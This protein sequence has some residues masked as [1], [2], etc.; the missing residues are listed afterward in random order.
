MA[1]SNDLVFIHG[2]GT[3]SVVWKNQTGYFSK[4]YKVEAID[5]PG[6][7]RN[8]EVLEPLGPKLLELK[9]SGRG[10]NSCNHRVLVG[11][12][13]GGMLSIEMAAQD[14][15]NLKALVLVS[16]SAKFTDEVM[17]LR[18]AVV[19]NIKRNL[20]RN[21]EDTMRNCYGTFFSEH[22]H[23][24][25]PGFIKEQDLPQK[26]YA[27]NIIDELITLDLTDTLKEIDIPVLIIHADRDGVCPPAA[28]RFLNKAVKNSKLY[29]IKNAG[30][31]PFY[32]RPGEFNAI[33]EGFLK[34]VK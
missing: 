16:T 15:G 24:Y 1:L 34:D 6:H 27:V 31:A 19:K 12:S 13:Y 25:I 3:S 14:A 5:L 9:P 18:L 10:P 2:W 21:F 33:L 23:E 7:G 11:W 22:E 17:G 8:P 30:H 28:G 20:E 32:T 26:E 29:I 4:N